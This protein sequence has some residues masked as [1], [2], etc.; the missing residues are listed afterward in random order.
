MFRAQLGSLNTTKE[1]PEYSAPERMARVTGS[2]EPL[3]ATIF[4]APMMAAAC[5]LLGVY[6]GWLYSFSLKVVESPGKEG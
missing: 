3:S 4:E 2:L 5:G 6:K 1:M